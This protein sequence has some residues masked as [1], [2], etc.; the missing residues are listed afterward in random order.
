MLRGKLRVQGLKE[1]GVASLYRD[2]VFTVMNTQT[3]TGSS[4]TVSGSTV[5]SEVTVT[6]GLPE[7]LPSGMFPLQVRIEA[8]NNNLTTT[9]ADLPVS[10][11]TSLFDSSKQTYYFIRTIEYKEYAQI[12]SGAYQYTT[13]I[14]CSFLR[15][16]TGTVT[17]K[18]QDIPGTEDDGTELDSY[19]AAMQ[20]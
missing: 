6:I 17:V 10:Y 7:E 1:N 20:L 19:F 9:S 14:P 13:Q 4:L 2:I 3:F 8:E 15:T 12:V 11:G 18:F 5:G 16:D